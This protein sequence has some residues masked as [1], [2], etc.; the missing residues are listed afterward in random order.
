MSSRAFTP[1]ELNASTS[2]ASADRF[3]STLPCTFGRIIQPVDL[4][5][6]LL[7]DRCKR[8][9]AIYNYKYNYYMLILGDIDAIYSLYVYRKPLYDDRGAIVANLP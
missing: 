1:L 3:R 8:P 2:Q 7:Y 5:L 9:E 6:L 4:L